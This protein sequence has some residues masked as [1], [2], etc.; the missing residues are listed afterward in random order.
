MA[1]TTGIVLA[2]FLLDKTCCSRS[3]NGDYQRCGRK[4]RS[5]FFQQL[6][7]HLWLYAQQNNLCSRDG[8]AIVRADRNAAEF[9]RQLLAAF[10][11]LH[12]GDGFLRRDQ[13]SFEKR[14]Q[15]DRSHL[16]AAE[17]RNFLLRPRLCVADGLDFSGGWTHRPQSYK[18][19]IQAAR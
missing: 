5:Y 7:Q 17:H 14:L 4:R 1:R 8:G 13:L 18:R 15:Q 11:M 3:G 2:Q 12:R 9:A 6:A 10:A 19:G 16:A